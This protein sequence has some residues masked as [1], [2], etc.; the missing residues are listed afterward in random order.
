MLLRC[1]DL[2]CCCYV[3]C[4]YA[5]I[6]LWCCC[7]VVCC[8]AAHD[9]VGWG[10]ACYRS[11]YFVRYM[12]L[13]CRDLWCCCYVLCCYAAEISGVVATLYVATLQRS[14][15]L[16]LPYMLLRCSW[17]GGVGG[18]HVNVPCTSYAICRYA[19][20]ISGVVA[21]FYVATLQ[22]SLV[23][24]LHYMLLRLDRSLVL[25]LRYMLLRCSW[26]GGVGGACYRSLYIVRYMLL[27][28]RDLWCCCYVLCCYAAH[29]GVG[30]GGAC[31]RSLY[32][33]R[34][35]SLRCRDLWCCCYVLCCY[36]AEISGVVAT[37]YVATLG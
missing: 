25:L 20:E 17:W 37:L 28:C 26:W 10:G 8:Y 7:Y 33:V 29:D 19:A 2:W 34:Y 1:R 36:A 14:L 32:F 27:R 5:W 22:R 21:T 35:M 24:L 9:G 4:C 13:R 6:N 23:L 30:W 18:W 31:Y 3:K 16:L 15:V 11:L 12:S